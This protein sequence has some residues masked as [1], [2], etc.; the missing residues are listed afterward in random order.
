MAFMIPQYTKEDFFSVETDNGTCVAPAADVGDD[1]LI[2][3]DGFPLD[4]AE[5][6]TIKGKWWC[7]LSAP[8]YTD[9]TEWSGP[10]DSLGEARAEIACAYDVCPT[11]GDDHEDGYTH[12]G[13]CA[14]DHMPEGYNEQ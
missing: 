2:C 3:I 7:R 14:P 10:F 13:E 12:C 1:F 11:T 8:G 6:E 4:G 9:C 5:V